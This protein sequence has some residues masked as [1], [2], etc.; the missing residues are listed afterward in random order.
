MVDNGIA[1]ISFAMRTN[2]GYL[3]TP[4]TLHQFNKSKPSPS[5]S[6]GSPR[7]LSI[8]LF[9][10]SVRC[11]NGQPFSLEHTILPNI[12]FKEW[13]LE[14]SLNLNADVFAK[15]LM[16]MW[17]LWKSRNNK[18]W[19]GKVQSTND[20]L[21]G[22]FTWLEEFHKARMSTTLAA[23]KTTKKWQAVAIPKLNIDGAFILQESYG[24]IGGVLRDPNG[25]FQAAFSKP[26]FHVNLAQQIELLA[27]KEG[28][29]FIKNLQIQNV[30][31][32][33]DCLVA[34]QEIT[35][36]ALNISVM[37]SIVLDIQ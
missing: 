26:V 3:E 8:S 29:Q 16:I 33:T 10:I 13:M 15:L 12:D 18:L 25:V 14:Q 2:I 7:Y 17:S 19:E 5:P 34:V 37:S 36:T 9:T 1:R 11:D 27:I 4:F 30:I 35:Y 21:L 24:G 31:V 28:L 22:C 20:I 32:E 6:I 23:L